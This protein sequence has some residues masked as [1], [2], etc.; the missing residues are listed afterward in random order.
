MTATTSDNRD[1]D[2]NDYN[3]SPRPTSAAAL[4]TMMRSPM[5]VVTTVDYGVGGVGHDDNDVAQHRSRKIR[6]AR[7]GGTRCHCDAYAA[8]PNRKLSRATA[9]EHCPAVNEQRH[10]S[11]PRHRPRPAF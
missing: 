5:A 11:G 10:R 7:R 6:A 1:G 4:M 3:D 9:N 2:G 8:P